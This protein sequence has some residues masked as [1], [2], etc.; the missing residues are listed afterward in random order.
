MLRTKNN[1]QNAFELKRIKE[2]DIEV[3]CTVRTKNHTSLSNSS[4][5][6]VESSFP[7]S[8]G[9]SSS[10]SGLGPNVIAFVAPLAGVTELAQNKN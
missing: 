2:T 10:E 6:K 8:K 5:S 3:G 9:K 7:L 4:R 1:I